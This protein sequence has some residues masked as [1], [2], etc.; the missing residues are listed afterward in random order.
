MK[1]IAEVEI[2]VNK[3]L[4]FGQLIHSPVVAWAFDMS[5]AQVE[6]IP[7]A[8]GGYAPFLKN[9]TTANFQL[10]PASPAFFQ[11]FY[12]VTSGRCLKNL[13]AEHRAEIKR[14]AGS[15]YLGLWTP[16]DTTDWREVALT[17]ERDVFEDF[18]CDQTLSTI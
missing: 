18:V 5:R 1:S 11:V 2:A 16:E 12:L 4:V 17:C 15:F 13:S 3:E 8:V 6:P 14:S 7:V 9:E 10:L